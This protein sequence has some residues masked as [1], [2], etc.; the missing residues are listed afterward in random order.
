MLSTGIPEL[1]SEKDIEHLHKAFAGMPSAPNRTGHLS[2]QEAATNMVQLIHL[3]LNT[4]SKQIDD[5][6]HGLK[7]K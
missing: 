2:D 1:E 7:H 3:A 6:L 4:K 5:M